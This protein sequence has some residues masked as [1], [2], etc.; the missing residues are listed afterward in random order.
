MEKWE[1]QVV[2]SKALMVQQTRQ[3]VEPLEGC[4]E[5]AERDIPFTYPLCSIAQVS[6]LDLY[7][8][9][10]GQAVLVQM[11]VGGQRRQEESGEILSQLLQSFSVKQVISPEQGF[12]GISW[13]YEERKSLK[14][15]FGN[16]ENEWSITIYNSNSIKAHQRVV[17]MNFPTRAGM[18]Q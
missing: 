17:V 2:E 7:R 11:M 8:R 5:W 14:Q 16:Q 3:K 13:R 4:A 6:G 9:K 15:L 12:E 1:K 10:A 18:G